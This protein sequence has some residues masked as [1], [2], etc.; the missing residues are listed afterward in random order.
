MPHA[1]SSQPSGMTV[2]LILCLI[3]NLYWL[4]TSCS[5]LVTSCNFQLGIFLRPL[6]YLLGRINLFKYFKCFWNFFFFFHPRYSLGINFFFSTSVLEK[7][8]C[9]APM[10]S[11]TVFTL[12]LSRPDCDLVA[13]R[14]ENVHI[15]ML[16]GKL[17]WPLQPHLW[18]ENMKYWF[19]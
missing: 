5:W 8:N 3:Y 19:F 2:C 4:V 9:M 14:A 1:N 7:L 17:G 15:Q 6:L 11:H 18:S 12:P 13:C 10:L 16:L